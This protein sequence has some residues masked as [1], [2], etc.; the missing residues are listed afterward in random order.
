MSCIRMTT[1]VFARRGEIKFNRFYTYEKVVCL[2]SDHK[3]EVTC[4]IHGPFWILPST[5]LHGIGCN[6]C[7]RNKTINA[8]KYTTETWLKGFNEKFGIGRYDYSKIKE[9]NGSAHRIEI[10]C[11]KKDKFGD[12]HGSFFL[13]ANAHLSGK[14]C[15]GCSGRRFKTQEYY[16]KEAEEIHGIG[17]YEYPGQY[18]GDAVKIEVFCPKEGHGIFLRSPG[19]LLIGRGCQKCAKSGTS[20]AEKEWLNS[21]HISALVYQKRIQ[22]TDGA[23]I[24]V[25]GYDPETNTVYEYHGKYWHSHPECI[26]CEPDNLH[27]KGSTY[28]DRYIST[29]IR[30]IRLRELGYKVVSK[31]G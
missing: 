21:L 1:D 8:Q 27:P 19:Q 17:T 11:R 4:P 24:K 26:D 28:G 10:I 3:V 31:W 14:G 5:H 18:M 7:G 29:I 2:G 22:M 15:R 16:V 6:E 30:E 9:I 25:D 13:A 23:W 12:E 20:K